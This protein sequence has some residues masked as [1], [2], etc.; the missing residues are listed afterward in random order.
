MANSYHKSERTCPTLSIDVPGKGGGRTKKTLIICNHY[1]LPAS[2]GANM[3][4]MHFVRFFQ[5]L[6]LV[7]IAYI[8]DLAGARTSATVFRNEIPLALAEQGRFRRRF[9]TGVMTGRPVPVFQ[10]EKTSREAILSRIST[11]DYDYILV[12]YI[13]ST[14]LLFDLPVR[15]QGRA[16]IDFDDIIS[17]PLYDQMI[18]D[19]D[20]PLKKWILGFNR[21][22]IQRYERECLGF[23]ASLVCSERDRKRLSEGNGR[24]P[25]VVPN[26]YDPGPFSA[27]DTGD[28][29]R[30]KNHLLFVGTLNYAPNVKGLRWF[31]ETIFPAFRRVYAD[32]KL[33]V[34]GRYPTEK[35]R[36]ICETTSGIELY[37][38]VE[39]IMAFYRD[40][41]AVV[42]PL[43][44]G[45]GTR[46]KILEA[47]FA[48]R[49][50]LST[51]VGAE[52]LEFR[53]G[54]ELL[55]FQ[56]SSGF[57]KGYAH[58]T[59]EEGYQSLITKA[60][61]VV[62]TRYSRKCFDDVMESVLERVDASR[63]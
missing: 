47:A 60:K 13:Y 46:I 2:T 7:D 27:Y 11:E 42:V 14:G 31:V 52:G 37:P 50:V 12:R 56:N 57:L 51:T 38:D 62:A 55:L 40:C 20:G 53:D 1:P 3:R 8:Y 45:G 39:D 21:R 9:L 6:G 16:I 26:V 30:Q 25:L 58:L 29:F 23:G 61:Q 44:A 48:M 17:G 10:Y 33:I 49:P 36:A 63:R 34:V 19:C 4:T 18:G 35:V 43:L 24:S 28:G 59:N 54:K 41:R 15:L 32:A 22:L 5:Q